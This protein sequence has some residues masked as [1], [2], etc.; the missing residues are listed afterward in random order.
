[1]AQ[2]AIEKLVDQATDPM[3]FQVDFDVNLQLVDRINNDTEIN[4][5]DIAVTRL[6]DRLKQWSSHDQVCWLCLE[7]PNQK[8]VFVSLKSSRIFRKHPVLLL[9]PP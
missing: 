9:I 8:F 6:R 5:V 3:L 7:V 4:A 1:M 2:Q